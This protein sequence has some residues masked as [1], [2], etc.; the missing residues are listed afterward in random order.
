V[1]QSRS[2][3]SGGSS[4]RERLGNRASGNGW[5]PGKGE[6]RELKPYGTR[7]LVVK[8]GTGPYDLRAFTSGFCP[9]VLRSSTTLMFRVLGL[10][11]DHD[12]SLSTQNSRRVQKKSQDLRIPC[13]ACVCLVTFPIRRLSRGGGILGMGPTRRDAFGI[14]HDLDWVAIPRLW[15]H[16]G[17]VQSRFLTCRASRAPDS[18]SQ[19]LGLG[20]ASWLAQGNREKRGFQ[21][22]DEPATSSQYLQDL[23]RFP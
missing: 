9:G 2:P 14:F 6:A 19:P 15:G 1:P 12:V 11:V 3:S 10:R 22:V 5:R 8:T 4:E 23:D 20:L 7:S 18:E 16:R 17:L 13:Q 21:N